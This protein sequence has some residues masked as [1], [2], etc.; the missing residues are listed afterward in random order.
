[1]TWTAHPAR[2]RPADLALVIAVVAITVAVVLESFGSALFGALAAAFLVAAVAPFLFPSRFVIT[3]E[4]IECERALSRR[5]RRFA[6]LRRIDVG[7]RTILVS[8]FP[9][10]S[11]LDRYRGLFLLLDGLD[12][13]GRAELVALLRRKVVAA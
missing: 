1:M 9:R 4:A 13:A 11:W 10:P 12:E 6:D 3:E 7:P 8:P 2:Q 5:T